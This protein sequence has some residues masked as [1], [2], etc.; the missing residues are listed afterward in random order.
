MHFEHLAIES[1]DL[2]HNSKQLATYIYVHDLKHQM[3]SF[4]KITAFMEG[5]AWAHGVVTGVGGL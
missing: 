4:D 3:Q 2:A 5:F 1:E